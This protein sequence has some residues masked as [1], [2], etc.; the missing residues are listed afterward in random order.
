MHF[1]QLLGAFVGAAA[2]GLARRW[3]VMD[4][5]ADEIRERLVEAR[6]HEHLMPGVV[7]RRGRGDRFAR[8]H[9]KKEH[10]FRFAHERCGRVGRVAVFLRDAR[11][12][13]IGERVRVDLRERGHMATWNTFDG[14]A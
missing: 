4:E 7:D 1:V 2:V 9:G 12:E 11:H 5:A 10:A 3:I 6:E 13:K 8:D 14:G